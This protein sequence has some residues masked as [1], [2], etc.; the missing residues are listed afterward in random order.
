[1]EEVV[2]EQAAQAP[3]HRISTSCPQDVLTAW[4]DAGRMRQV[5]ANLIVNAIKY[6]PQGGRVLVHAWS[7]RDDVLIS[8]TD[9]GIGIARHE[10]ARLFGR[11]Q[12]LESAAVSR[13]PGSGLGLHICQRIIEAHGGRIQAKSPPP[14]HGAPPLPPDW[15]GGTMFTVRVPQHAGTYGCLE[16]VR[17]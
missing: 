3:Q 8:V 11:F 14:R 15:R 17:A 4:W 10:M 2:A 13:A 9:E 12:R 7:E 5:L 1:V 16:E 6:S